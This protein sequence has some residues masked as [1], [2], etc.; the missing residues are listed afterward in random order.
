VSL[1]NLSLEKKMK[2]HLILTSLL[3]LSI[4]FTCAV[5]LA[6]EQTGIKAHNLKVTLNPDLKTI[7]GSDDLTFS[8]AS[9]GEFTFTLNKN[10]KVTAISSKGTQLTFETGPYVG[11]DAGETGDMSNFQMIKVSLP[12]K[13]STITIEYTGEIYDPIEPSKALAHIRGDYTSGIISPEGVYLSSETGWYPDTLNALATFNV[14]VNVPGDWFDV[15]QGNLIDRKEAGGRRISKWG[16][17]I[18]FDGC[19]LVAN[20]YFVRTRKIDGVDCSTYFYQDVPEL[21]DTFLNKLEEYLPVYQDLFGPYPYSRFD[22]VENFFS[23]GYGMAGYTLLGNA[24]VRMPFATLEGSLAHELVHCWWGNYVIPD[25]D[26]GNWCEGLTYYSTN[27]YWNVVKGLDDKAKDFRF[28]DMLKYTLQVS[29]DEDYPV[30]QFRTKFTDVDGDIGYGKS[31]AIFGMIHN[32]LGDQMFF[33]SLKLVVKKHGGQKATWDDF[34]SAFEE[35]SGEDLSVFFTTWLDNKG[36][37]DF[38][39]ASINEDKVDNKYDIKIDMIQNKPLFYISLPVVIKSQ[40]NESKCLIKTT[41]ES[42]SIGITAQPKTISVALDPDYTI[43]RRLDHEEVTP[44]L[45]A[46]LES[47]SILVVLPSGGD[48]DMLDMPSGGMMGGGGGPMG[49]APAEKVSV[50]KMYEDLAESMT[51]SGIK[52]TVKY[53]TEVTDE[54]LA[55]SSVLCLGASKYNSLVAQLT[56]DSNGLIE[57]C[58]NCFSVNGTEYSSENASALVTVRNP[59]NSKYYITFHLGNSPQA[60]FKASYMFFYRSF[61]YVIYESGNAVTREKWERVNTHVYPVK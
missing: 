60:V 18:P 32:M 29:P 2:R 59:Y 38:R 30:R 46:T 28:T 44:C 45:D 10:L 41:G 33:D 3:C 47:D 50:K 13:V 11:P 40:D 4:L 36:T 54:D 8:S 31:G 19:V 22:V 42:F 17:D 7:V 12:K 34:R 15:T 35:T 51:E 1:V 55:K 5:S 20:K 16:C 48:A 25:W 61:S 58:D 37:P 52:A 27:Y 23:T 43:F 53:D 24:V 26:K 14:E 6:D 39:T 9:S 57:L 56:G 21:S 49:G